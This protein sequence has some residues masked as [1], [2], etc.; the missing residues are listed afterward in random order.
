MRKSNATN[1]LL[2]ET[3]AAEILAVEPRTL[4]LWRHRGLPFIRIRSNV[5]RYR[6]AD[7]DSWRAQ[8]RVAIRAKGGRVWAVERIRGSNSRW[9]LRI[10]WLAAGPP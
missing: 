6:R 7:L 1:D 5:I 8:R 9:R 10:D 3:Q 4:K 2:T